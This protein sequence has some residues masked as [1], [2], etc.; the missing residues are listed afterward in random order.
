MPEK[1]EKKVSE[2]EKIIIGKYYYNFVKEFKE[3]VKSLN[4]LFN[5]Y[6][7]GCEIFKMLYC[8]P[9]SLE[10]S[11]DN[12]IENEKTLKDLF[13]DKAIEEYMGKVESLQEQIDDLDYNKKDRDD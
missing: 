2:L 13:K 9:Y 10:I 4:S 1:N 8:Q 3:S 7:V 11:F 6:K 12:N 5:K